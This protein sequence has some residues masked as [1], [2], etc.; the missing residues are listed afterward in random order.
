MVSFCCCGNYA[1]VGHIGMRIFNS[2]VLYVIAAP[3]NVPTLNIS[4]TH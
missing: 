4:K 2:V 3:H 1:T